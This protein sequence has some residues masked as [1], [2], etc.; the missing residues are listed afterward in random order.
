MCDEE[1]DFKAGDITTVTDMIKQEWWSSELVDPTLEPGRV[2][3]W[4]THV[5]AKQL[6]VDTMQAAASATA[7]KDVY[8]GWSTDLILWCVVAFPCSKC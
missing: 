8:G 7:D 1:L 4:E 5:P 3:G 6:C 2:A